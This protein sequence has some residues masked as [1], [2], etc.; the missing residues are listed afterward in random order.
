MDSFSFN[1]N[2]C[3]WTNFSDKQKNRLNKNSVVVVGQI[4]K[5][6]HSRVYYKFPYNN[7]VYE[8]ID[9]FNPGHNYYTGKQSYLPVVCKLPCFSTIQK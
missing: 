9:D 1:Y 7:M 6:T 3:P 4:Y 2:Y 8:D 5:V